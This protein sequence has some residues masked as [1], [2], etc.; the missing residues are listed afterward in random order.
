MSNSYIFMGKLTRP[1]EK[2]MFSKKSGDGGFLIKLNLVSISGKKMFE[3]CVMFDSGEELLRLEVGDI[4]VVRGTRQPNNY[5][6]DGKKQYNQQVVV[7]E[8]M[9]HKEISGAA[10]I[11]TEEPPADECVYPES[12]GD[13]IPF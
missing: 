11:K 2:K 1:A 4:V 13:D 10:E 12:E 8:Y 5:E 7:G 9:I 3:N 6:V